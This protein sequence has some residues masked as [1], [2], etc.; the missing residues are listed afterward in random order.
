M[1]LVMK[2]STKNSYRAKVYKL[3]KAV[4]Q[5]EFLNN[6]TDVFISMH[7]IMHLML[8]TRSYTELIFKSF[9]FIFNKFKCL[10]FNLQRMKTAS[11]KQ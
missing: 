2:F 9:L 7:V 3:H 1:I 6:Y 4:N 10:E 11:G 5:S 8:H